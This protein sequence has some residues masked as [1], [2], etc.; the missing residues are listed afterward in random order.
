MKLYHGTAGESVPTILKHGVK[1]R[2]AT[3]KNNWEH[4]VASHEHAV[5]LASAYEIRAAA[6]HSRGPRCSREKRIRR[7]ISTYLESLSKATR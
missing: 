5:Y 6:G 2:R 4:S 3:K 7:A 1:P